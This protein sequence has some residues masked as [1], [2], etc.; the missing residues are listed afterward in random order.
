MLENSNPSQAT[1]LNT[2]IVELNNSGL[3]TLPLRSTHQE[4]SAVLS[5]T[6]LQLESATYEPSQEFIT[7]TAKRKPIPNP[8]FYPIQSRTNPMDIFQS[9]VES[10]ISDLLSTTGGNKQYNLSYKER[11]ALKKLQN[12][13]NIVIRPSDKGGST[14]LLDKGL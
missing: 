3:Y 8:S 10:K 12:N 1:E 11:L 14:V 4:H 7:G 13:S 5:L 6:N 9:T 2:L